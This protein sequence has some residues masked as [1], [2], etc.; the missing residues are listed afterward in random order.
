MFATSSTL[1]S[2]SNLHAGDNSQWECTPSPDFRSW[3]CLRDGKGPVETIPES[4]TPVPA[5][6]PTDSTS[7]V[8]T[9]PLAQ[10][11]PV[12]PSELQIETDT[13][14]AATEISDQAIQWEHNKRDRRR[15]PG[16]I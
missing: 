16:R 9:T 8:T 4:A 14:P 3:N 13:P 10:P 15:H 5:V 11:E 1:L 7:E 12:Q 2:Y 6:T